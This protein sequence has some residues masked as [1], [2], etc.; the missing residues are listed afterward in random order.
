MLLQRSVGTAGSWDSGFSDP[1]ARG[2]AEGRLSLHVLGRSLPRREAVIASGVV[3]DYRGAEVAKQYNREETSGGPAA[4]GPAGPVGARVVGCSFSPRGA[5]GAHGA[6]HSPAGPAN[7]FCR[8]SCHVGP[9]RHARLF[10]SLRGNND[11]R[12]AAPLP[13]HLPGCRD[14]GPSTGFAAAL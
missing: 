8:N 11:V 10:L 2:V 14:G 12:V 13:S 6:A 9:L 4:W 7:N 3:P 5:S 1:R